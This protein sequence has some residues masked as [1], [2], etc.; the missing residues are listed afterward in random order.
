LLKVNL[1]SWNVVESVLNLLG[2]HL[3][4]LAVAYWRREE[5]SLIRFKLIV[6]LLV[7]IQVS[8]VHYSLVLLIKASLLSQV[9]GIF[10]LRL[11]HIA[12]D[13]EPAIS[14]DLLV[15]N[16]QAFEAATQLTQPLRVLDSWVIIQAV[17]PLVILFL[18]FSG[19]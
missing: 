15:F 8:R 12:V 7:Y 13:V 3:L 9:L 11:E 10:G 6:D 2:L 1:R 17:S 4:G 16:V 18:D 5:L 19:F 14:R